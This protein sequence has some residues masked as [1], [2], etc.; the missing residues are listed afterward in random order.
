MSRAFR[1]RPPVQLSLGRQFNNIAAV[2]SS[3]R[4][5][6]PNAEGTSISVS[7]DP[8]DAAEV[9]RNGA[10]RN[11]FDPLTPGLSE[12]GSRFA[13]RTS[14]EK[15]V[16]GIPEDSGHDERPVYAWLRH[17]DSTER[18]F[19]SAVFDVHPGGRRT[20]TVAGDSLQRHAKNKIEMHHAPGGRSS[21]DI[22]KSAASYIN[23]EDLNHDHQ[24]IVTDMIDRALNHRAPAY[25]EVQ[26]HGG[27]VPASNIERA[28]L[29]RDGNADSSID[30]ARDA[31]RSARIP[32]RVLQHMEYQPTLDKKMF[33]AG[34]TGWVDEDSYKRRSK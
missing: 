34:K 7:M 14:M 12:T 29:Y 17:S 8:M 6:P 26:I 19:G 33:G 23:V 20:T 18:P 30:V 22:D 21:D 28:T 2:L 32:T 25:R 27:A 4:Q 1:R 5:G 24:P 15:H 9:G 10:I 3:G 13:D 16:F 11:G 31:L